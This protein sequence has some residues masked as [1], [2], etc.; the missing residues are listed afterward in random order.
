MVNAQNIMSGVIYHEIRVMRQCGVSDQLGFPTVA[1]YILICSSI[2]ASDRLM[3][4][5]DQS[6]SQYS[7]RLKTCNML[8]PVMC[9][10]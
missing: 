4:D 2:Q 1:E 3:I 9:Q 7:N 8:R 5:D 10:I 6:I